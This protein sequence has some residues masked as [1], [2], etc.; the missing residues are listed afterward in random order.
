MKVRRDG[1][2]GWKPF[3]IVFT[4]ESEA[5]ARALYAIFNYTPNTDLLP[6]AVEV[7][8]RRQLGSKFAIPFDG[9]IANGVTYGDFYRSKEPKE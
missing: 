9:E 5:E 4:V 3:D 2:W 7:D 1:G 6:G 8:V